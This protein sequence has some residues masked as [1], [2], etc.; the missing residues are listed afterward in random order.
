[1]AIKI[2]TWAHHVCC[3]S[4]NVTL[5]QGMKGKR[6]FM[7]FVVPLLLNESSE[8]RLF[9][10]SSKYIVKAI[11][12][13]NGNKKPPMSRA[14]SALIMY[15][16]TVEPGKILLHPLHIKLGLIKNFVNAMD[17]EG[18]KFNHLRGLFPHLS[19]AKLKEGIFVG[20]QIRKLICDPVFESNL[21]QKELAA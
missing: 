21:N 13:Y 14:Y 12:L 3:E 5:V 19:E 20:P 4:C 18:G 2:K 16:P 6:T 9:I 10:D 11:L 1:M 15:T 7:L 17:K 8:R